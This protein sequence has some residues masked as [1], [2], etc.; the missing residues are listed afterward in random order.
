[1]VNTVDSTLGLI[2]R[3]QIFASSVESV[4]FSCNNTLNEFSA[5]LYLA[6]F[7]CKVKK[8]PEQTACT[9]GTAENT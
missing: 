4:F 8:I 3:T 6:P 9:L 5:C 1:M 7:D 2:P